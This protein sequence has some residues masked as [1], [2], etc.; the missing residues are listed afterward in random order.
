MRREYLS[1][2]S[3]FHV[4]KR[5]ARGQP[6]VKDNADRWR[7]LRLHHYLNDASAK[8][9]WL[10]EL[11][12]FRSDSPAEHFFAWPSSWPTRKPLFTMCGFTF[13][14]NHR[15]LIGQATKEGG[16]SKFMHKSG[17]S[18]TKH[19]NEKYK[20]SGTI[21]Q[22]SYKIIIIDSDKYLRWVIPY[23]MCKNTFE[24]HPKGFTWASAH[25]DE[26]WEW[27]IKYPFS[28]LGD[29][30]GERN[31]PIVDTEPIKKILG[32]PKEFK[33]LCRDMI[34]GRGSKISGEMSGEILEKIG[35]LSFEAQV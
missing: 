18:E 19:F 5:G 28:S 4:I 26:A 3:F 27:G 1:P 22:G 20:E 30:A 13:L 32:G 33:R 34:L 29:Y 12:T 9:N 21:F 24:M 2:G 35:S 11:E 7:C 8:D 6:M 14:D 15:H 25:F 23:V 31:S 17:I 10:R 16:F